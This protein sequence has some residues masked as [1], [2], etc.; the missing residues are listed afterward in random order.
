[1][2]GAVFTERGIYRPGEPLFAKAI[3]RTGPLGALTR[4]PAADSLRWVFEARADQN[5]SPGALR[6]TVVAL[7]PFGTADQRFMIPAS[8]SVRKCC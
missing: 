5:G 3:V 4:P 8:T 2:A 6:D 7:S 1:M